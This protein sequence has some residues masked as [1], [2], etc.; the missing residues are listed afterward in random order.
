MASAGQLLCAAA[1]RAAW[2]AVF[3]AAAGCGDP[4]GAATDSGSGPV[5]AGTDSGSGPLPAGSGSG[6]VPAG[7]DRGPGSVPAEFQ[8]ACGKPGSTVQLR[9]SSGTI[10]HAACNLTGVTLLVGEKGGAV[11]PKRGQG[12]AGSSGLLVK[13]NQRGDVSYHVSQTD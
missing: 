12:V 7:T 5:P 10:P 4:G 2:G 9:S 11:V 3:L 13:R 8:D 1:R 6:P